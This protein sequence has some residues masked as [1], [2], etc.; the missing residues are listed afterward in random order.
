MPTLRSGRLVLGDVSNRRAAPDGDGKLGKK[1]VRARNLF[2]AT[3]PAPA[4]TVHSHGLMSGA[5]TEP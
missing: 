5:E 3:S 2:F 4:L 1:A